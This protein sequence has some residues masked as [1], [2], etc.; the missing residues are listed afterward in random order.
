MNLNLHV[1][2]SVAAITVDD[3]FHAGEIGKIVETAEQV[4]FLSQQLYNFAKNRNISLSMVVHC[5][6]YKLR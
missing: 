6:L 4:C 1:C 3:K 2:P 5:L